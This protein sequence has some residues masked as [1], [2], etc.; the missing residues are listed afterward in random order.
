MYVLVT[1]LSK[2]DVKVEVDKGRVLQISG[3]W[4]AEEELIDE[5]ENKNLGMK[6]HRV[7]RNRG[8]FCRKFRL[9][10]NIKADQVKASM[11]N[12]VLIVTIPK[13]DV[14]KP[15]SKLIEIEEK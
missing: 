3:K 5:K 10:Q 15:F 6:W 8:N 7:E 12:G 9:P 14:K 11:E 4:K 13:E 1:G 2:E